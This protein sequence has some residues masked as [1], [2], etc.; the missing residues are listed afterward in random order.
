MAGLGATAAY[1]AVAMAIGQV[2]TYYTHSA[3]HCQL[4]LLELLA[5][6]AMVFRVPRGTEAAAS[7]EGTMAGLAAAA[8]YAAV[9]MAIGQVRQTDRAALLLDVF[10]TSNQQHSLVLP[11]FTC[12]LVL[13]NFFAT[14][15]VVC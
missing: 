14:C 5:M 1:A 2:S 12:K 7:L 6:C 10:I 3:T 9:A 13:L 15:A 8:A 11:K 4:L